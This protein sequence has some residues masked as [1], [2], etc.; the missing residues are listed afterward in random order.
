MLSGN[1][2]INCGNVGWEGGGVFD[3]GSGMTAPVL[4][5]GDL[6]VCSIEGGLDEL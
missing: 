3:V 2:E 6:D 5:L 4:E 1:S